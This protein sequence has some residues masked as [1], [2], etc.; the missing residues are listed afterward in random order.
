MA[1]WTST[2]GP[3]DVKLCVVTGPVLLVVAVSQ[4][5]P[6]LLAFVAPDVFYE[7][8][9]GFPPRNDHFLR[10]LGSWQIGLGLVALAAWRLP[11]LRP[12]VLVALAMQ[13]AL[14]AIS[15]LVDVDAADPGWLGPVT[16]ALQVLGA[17]VLTTLAIRERRA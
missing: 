1:K 6:G 11:A 16:L 15:H 8:L 17:V 2:E 10:D 9:A 13:Y 4:L 12:G 5:V 3:A 14:H 7:T